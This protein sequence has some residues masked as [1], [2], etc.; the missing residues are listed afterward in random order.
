MDGFRFLSPATRMERMKAQKLKSRTSPR[1]EEP[2]KGETRLNLKTT[3]SI[4][5]IDVT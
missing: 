2:G 4:K 5:K 1:D 3:E